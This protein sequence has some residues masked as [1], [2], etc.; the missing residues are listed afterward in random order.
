MEVKTIK[1][2]LINEK[3]T[4]PQLRLN[5]E[6]GTHGIVS[7]A[8][9]LRLAENSGLDLV[10]IAPLA[11]PP[12]AKIMDYGKFKFDFLKRE[13]EARKK[14]KVS[15]LKE[16]QLSLYIADNDLNIKAKKVRKFLEEGDKVKVALKMH[17]RQLANPE[18]GIPVV[19]K[20]AEILSD[21]SEISQQPA[22][23]GRQIIMILQ[24]L[25]K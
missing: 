25:K 14:Q 6:T 7:L 5:T 15:E 4:A 16:M 8:E 20:F 19:R 21:I 12:V 11:E 13:K 17:G 22:V 10:L 1:E 18:Q 3:I 9:A 24:P 23:N 2:L